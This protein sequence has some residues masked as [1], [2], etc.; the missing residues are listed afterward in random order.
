MRSR[1]PAVFSAFLALLM[2]TPLRG[3][4]EEEAETDSGARREARGLNPYTAPSIEQIF[5]RLDELKPLPFDLVRRDFA[6]GSHAGRE[7]I[8]MQFGGS[9]ADGFLLVACQKKNM[10]DELGRVLL[11]QARSL[12]VGQRVMRHSA[13]LTELGRRGDWRAMRSEL[14]A[15][16]T[17]VEQ[18]MVDLHDQ[19][20]AQLIS[21][22][23]W[24]R[25]LE[26]CAAA[27]ETQYTPQRAKTLAQPDLVAYFW[28]E[29]R[30]LP[31]SVGQTPLFQEIRTGL[32]SVRGVVQKAPAAGLTATDAKALH[33]LARQMNAAVQRE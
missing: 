3:I 10:V 18:A 9:V 1:R 22:G 26:I 6:A 32:G 14:M 24:L 33:T 2:V 19:K 30:T 5:Q 7:Q 15:T 16:Q 21:L 11:R 20:M 23:G 13:S 8:G 12:G 28:D 25:G 17:D 31:P 27:V 4:T 29:I